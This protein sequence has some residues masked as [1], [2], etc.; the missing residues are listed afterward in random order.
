VTAVDT[1]ERE[2]LAK[3]LRE[4]RQVRA[5]LEEDLHQAR[6]AQKQMQD[7]VEHL[8]QQLQVVKNQ[9]LT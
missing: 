8:Q 1:S 6:V 4:E 9:N 5:Q 2:T 7:H 3:Q